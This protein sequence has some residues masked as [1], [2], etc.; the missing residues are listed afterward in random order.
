[1]PLDRPSAWYR[2]AL[3][4]VLIVALV[5][6]VGYV[7]SLPTDDASIA[8]L[9]DQSEYLSLARSL[10]GGNG[11]VFYDARF[12]SA[13][14]AYRAPLYPA[15]VAA[16]GGQVVVARLAQAALDASTAW[17]AALLALAL[18][19]PAVR[20]PGAVLAAIGVAVDPFLIYFCGLVLSETLFTAMLAWGM[21]LLLA[22][23]RGGRLTATDDAGEPLPY[24]PA[25][26]TL[27][28]LG[29]GLILAASTLVRPSAAPLAVLLGIAA[30]FAGRP[31]D[32]R[33]TFRPRWPLPVGATMALV[34]VLALL[35]WAYRNSRVVGQWVW[36]TTNGGVTAYDGFN[37]DADGSSD[38]SSLRAMPQLRLMNEVERSTYLSGRAAEFVREQPKRALELAALKVARTWSPMPLSA[39][40]GSWKHRLVGLAYCVP[41]YLLTLIGLSGLS[42]RRAAKAF[43]LTPIAY[44]TLVH[45][46]T[47]G[48]LR[49]RV[50][51]EPLL[52]VVA[53]AGLSGL[54]RPEWPWRRAGATEVSE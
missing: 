16:C 54:N 53:A 12:A 46:A 20:R 15:F 7:L 41:L 48:S 30:A 38:Q 47:V 11:L 19:P 21:V 50:P 5:L 2:R 26:G 24:R 43:L 4:A 49:Y 35:P 28:W 45:M 36:T 22:G 44:F 25:L 42:L 32:G 6:R 39:E 3:A 13:T 52:V 8:A 40:Y 31:R 1:M 23:S 29:G 14:Y 34:T 9:P 18:L 33:P 27:L 37:P 10:L 17:A 51:I